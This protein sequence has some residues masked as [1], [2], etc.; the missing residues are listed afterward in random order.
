[1]QQQQQHWRPTPGANIPIPPPSAMSG[2]QRL[3]NVIHQS[4]SMEI[5]QQQQQQHVSSSTST[6]TATS[7][8]TTKRVSFFQET[9]NKTTTREDPDVSEIVFQ[10]FN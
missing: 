2:G 3:D 8:T 4:S 5:T 7:T 1:M 6:S 9:D 10:T